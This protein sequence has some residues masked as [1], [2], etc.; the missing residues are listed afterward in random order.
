MLKNLKIGKKLFVLVVSLLVCLS[1]VGG[2]SIVL[3][4]Q[5]N[6]ASTQITGN[7]LP[8]LVLAEEMNKG[9]SDYRNYETDH[10]LSL[11]SASMKKYEDKMAA[12]KEEMNQKF[13]AYEPYFVS[14][15]DRKNLEQ[16]KTAWEKYLQTSSKLI[17]LSKKNQTQQAYAI[18]TGESSDLFENASKQFLTIVE[19]NKTGAE[20]ASN[21]GDSLFNFS[22]IAISIILVGAIILSILLSSYIVRLIV[23]PINEINLAAKQIVEGNFE[24]TLSY[25]SDDE[26]GMMAKAFA[27]M[28]I[29]LK[30]MIDD[31]KYLLGALAAGDFTVTSKCVEF[32][33]GGYEEILTAMRSLRENLSSTLLQIDIASKQ[34]ETGSDQVSSGAQALSQG[35][36]EQAAAIEQLSATINEALANI[37][38]NAQSA[39][40][41]NELVIHSGNGVKKSNKS[42]QEMI[43]AMDTLANSSNEIEKI[44]KTIEDIAFQ[45]NILAL[46]AAVEAARAGNAGKGFAVVADEVRNLAQKSADAAKTTTLHIQSVLTAIQNSTNMANDTAASLETVVQDT[47]V[48][49]EKIKDIASTSEQQADSMEQITIG[50]DQISS[51]VQT[52]S[53]T[54][55]ESAAAAEELN[56]QAHILKDLINQFQ[57]GEMK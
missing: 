32:Y 35:T 49:A 57:L 20:D 1:I 3:M 33:V 13:T 43:T 18:L 5:I 9:I 21:Y 37:K 11:D 4:K 27:Q 31:I 45:T 17:E 42:M 55:E 2:S 40:E 10:I 41:A 47:G 48:V 7:W 44:I 36:V 29:N 6:G 24:S 51:V 8:S 46:N 34:V 30:T 54:A 28:T 26:V 50:I 56:G 38:G 53:A 16:A 14:D 22:M 23:K 19:F 39:Q 52:N 15:T 12:L 25:N